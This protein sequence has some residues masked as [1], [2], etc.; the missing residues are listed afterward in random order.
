[1]NTLKQLKADNCFSNKDLAVMLGVS[2]KYITLAL[3]KP[4]S[5]QMSASVDVLREN[6]ELKKEIEKLK[7][8]ILFF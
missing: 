6:I 3:Y 1:M 7:S 5:K 4:L 2:E 8:A